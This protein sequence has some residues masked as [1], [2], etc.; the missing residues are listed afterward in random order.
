V[1]GVAA[2]YFPAARTT[3]VRRPHRLADKIMEADGWAV[4]VTAEAV[5]FLTTYSHTL[6]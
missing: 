2:T 4:R 5:T 1:A 3:G 6:V